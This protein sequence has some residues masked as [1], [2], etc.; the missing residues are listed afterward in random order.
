MSFSTRC[1]RPEDWRLSAHFQASE[2]SAPD[3]MGYEFVLWL[4]AVRDKAGVPMTITSSYRTPAHNVAVG[5]AEDSAHCDIPCNA[6]DIGMRPRADDSHWNYS[7][8]QII[9]AAM[10]L[11]CTRIGI[12]RDGSLHLDRSEDIRPSPRCWIQVDNPA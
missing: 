11:G 6:V 5:G 7:R 9:T 3:H 10:A 12:Y 8:Y 4:N 1:M 2:F